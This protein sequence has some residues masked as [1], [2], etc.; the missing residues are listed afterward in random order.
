MRRIEWSRRR[1]P[2]QQ[3]L[4]CSKISY[5]VDNRPMFSLVSY[6]KAVGRTIIQSQLS[7]VA[8]SPLRLSR[9]ERFIF[10]GPIRTG[11]NKPSKTNIRLPY[12][13]NYQAISKIRNKILQLRGAISLIHIDL[14][15][16]AQTSSPDLMLL[17]I[18]YLNKH[19]HG[20]CCHSTREYK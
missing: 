11:R 1:F 20:I 3:A 12:D 7:I 10:H 18:R 8:N 15:I 16:P 14:S 5:K 13:R 4:S 6:P 19:N 9:D 2:R 17:R